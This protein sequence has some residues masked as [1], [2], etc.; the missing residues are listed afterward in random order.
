MN[1]ENDAPNVILP[2]NEFMSKESQAFIPV[3][4]HYSF[5][6]QPIARR[7]KILCVSQNKS[8]QKSFKKEH[9]FVPF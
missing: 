4:I 9:K 2:E 6:I 5:R 1:V 7:K 8:S 3:V